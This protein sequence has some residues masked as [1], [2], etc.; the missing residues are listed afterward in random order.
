MTSRSVWGLRPPTNEIIYDSEVESVVSLASM[1]DE[2]ES[3][4]S[5][6]EAAEEVPSKKDSTRGELVT[7]KIYRDN[8]I[9]RNEFMQ[10]VV[11]DKRS[12]DE[13]LVLTSKRGQ[14]RVYTAAQVV[15]L[16]DLV[17]TKGYAAAAAGR[18]V[19]IKER[20][21]QGYV[22]QYYL[23]EQQ[24]VPIP[25]RVHNNG[26]AEVESLVNTCEVVEELVE[27]LLAFFK[28]DP[29]RTLEEA[30]VALEAG[31]PPVT[32]SL[33]ALQTVLR[34]TCGLTYKEVQI[35]TDVIDTWRA[36][37]D[38]DIL[39]TCVFLDIAGF[40]L[41]RFGWMKREATPMAQNV[42]ILGAICEIGILKVQ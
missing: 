13:N 42:V 35:S 14:Y 23:D 15:D 36:L 21:A 25:G 4:M 28:D 3:L 10:G 24:C 26:D 18:K 31:F 30:K 11:K 8:F 37:Q 9:P 20:T 17:T 16:I 5:T 38:L 34:E 7:L 41:D 39:R 6:F 40:N 29:T 19:G 33:P 32:I 22:R 2:V 1:D 12:N 27:F